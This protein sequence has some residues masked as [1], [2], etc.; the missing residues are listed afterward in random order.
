[1]KLSNHNVVKLDTYTIGEKSKAG[2]QEVT[3][4]SGG[5][6]HTGG[7]KSDTPVYVKVIDTT[8]QNGNMKIIVDKKKYEIPTSNNKH[9]TEDKSVHVI[10]GETGDPIAPKNTSY[11]DMDKNSNA[12]FKLKDTGKVDK[13]DNSIMVIESSTGE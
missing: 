7:K 12:P 1:M 9:K 4:N 3:V 10:D 6:L 13:K 5:G 11:D 8:K 2:Y